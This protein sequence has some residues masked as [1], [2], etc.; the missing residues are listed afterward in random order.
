MVEPS[1]STDQLHSTPVSVDIRD[2]IERIMKPRNFTFWNEVEE[3][4]DLLQKITFTHY[5]IKEC[6]LNKEEPRLRYRCVVYVCTFGNK[7]KPEGTGKRKKGTKYVGCESTIRIRYDFNKFIISTYNSVHNHPCNSEYL[8]NDS[9]FRRLSRNESEEIAQMITIGWK[10]SEVIKY[11]DENFNKTITIS[12][13]KNLRNKII[14]DFGKLNELDLGICT[15]PE[16]RAEIYKM[17]NILLERLLRLQAKQGTNWT[18]N[19]IN[20][21][22]NMA[23]NKLV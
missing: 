9:W 12:D 23:D 16:E 7:N 20:E 1:A 22:I 18:K 11:V 8:S 19:F 4:L 10:P 2:A 13:Y 15:E 21:L 17:N 3:A 5:V 6:K 14:K